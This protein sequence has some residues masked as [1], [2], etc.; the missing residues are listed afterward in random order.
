MQG[1]HR[2]RIRVI[3]RVMVR[4]R[5]MVRVWVS[6]GRGLEYLNCIQGFSR[7]RIL[8]NNWSTIVGKEWLK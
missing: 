1:L 8:K 5:A 6:C 4:V 7:V 3:V 2:V